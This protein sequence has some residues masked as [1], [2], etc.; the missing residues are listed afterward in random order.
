MWCIWDYSMLLYIL[1]WI[2]LVVGWGQRSGHLL[3]PC[4]IQFTHV[5]HVQ[6]EPLKYSPLCPFVDLWYWFLPNLLVMHYSNA[7]VEL[8]PIGGVCGMYNALDA[9]QVAHFPSIKMVE[10]NANNFFVM[11]LFFKD[12]WAVGTRNQRKKQPSEGTTKATQKNP[13]LASRSNP[14]STK[15]NH[16]FKLP[17]SNLHSTCIT[18]TS[19][20]SIFFKPFSLA[21]SGRFSHPMS[22]LSSHVDISMSIG[23]VTT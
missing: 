12:R 5:Q 15:Q 10:H 22:G 18:C 4:W 8:Q 20:Y 19:T 17:F 23:N 9:I 16:Q 1:S 3:P 13:A 2:L 6:L 14:T 7:K 11:G 21:I